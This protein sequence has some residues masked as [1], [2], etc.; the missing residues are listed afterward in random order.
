MQAEPSPTAFEIAGSG[1]QPAMF[2]PL[3]ALHRA[4][5]A[6]CLLAACAGLGAWV[7]YSFGESSGPMLAG[8]SA[9]IGAGIGAAVGIAAAFLLLHD[10]TG[11]TGHHGP[12]GPAPHQV[13][14]R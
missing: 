11:L 14:I 5:V 10:F 6:L 3:P 2:G 13:R 12:H 8:L 7:N 9:G 4:L 1:N